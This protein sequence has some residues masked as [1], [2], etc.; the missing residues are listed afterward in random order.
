[1]KSRDAGEGPV[2]SVHAR[3]GAAVLALCMI[4]SLPAWA[5]RPS[6]AQ[7]MSLSEAAR[8]LSASGK[9][10]VLGGR[11]VSIGGR[12]VHR[13]KVVTPTGRVQQIKVEA[14]TGRVIVDSH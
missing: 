7:G 14:D 6:S 1:M 13:F 3:Y 12:E 5:A 4:L 2:R 10:R 11:T 9:Y 8:K